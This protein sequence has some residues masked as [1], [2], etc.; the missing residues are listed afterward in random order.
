MWTLTNKH[1]RRRRMKFDFAFLQQ[2]K[3]GCVI[4]TKRFSEAKCSPVKLAKNASWLRGQE[5]GL[6]DA[7]ID[8]LFRLSLLAASYLTVQARSSLGRRRSGTVSAQVV[9]LLLITKCQMIHEICMK[10][11]HLFY[12][13]VNNQIHWKFQ[14]SKI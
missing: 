13:V 6:I 4:K 12:T 9:K 1:G 10:K 7:W 8:H 2:Q 14:L 11:F 5:H 3:T